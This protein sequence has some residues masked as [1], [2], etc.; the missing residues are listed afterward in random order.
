MARKHLGVLYS[1]LHP[2]VG[3]FCRNFSLAIATV[4]LW[5]IHFVWSVLADSLLIYTLKRD[6]DQLISVLDTLAPIAKLL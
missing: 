3:T 6:G 4:L 1:G 5:I 2:L